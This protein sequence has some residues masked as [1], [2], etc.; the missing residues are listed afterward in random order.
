MSPK[1]MGQSHLSIMYIGITLK[2]AFMWMSFQGSPFS[3]HGM[4]I[5]E[6]ASPRKKFQRFLIDFIKL[7]QQRVAIARALAE[8][9]DRTRPATTAKIVAKATA[10]TNANKKSPPIA[11]AS[12]GA[13]IFPAAFEAMIL[14]YPTKA[15]APKP[16]KMADYFYP[17]SVDE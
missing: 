8:A 14:S 2:K 15:A 12:N 6:K 1:K 9:A 4:R 7:K 11:S 13:A 17:W 10:D 5:M 3:V 16:R